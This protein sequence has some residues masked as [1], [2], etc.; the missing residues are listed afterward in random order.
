[1]L[2][3]TALPEARHSHQTA[4]AQ[5]ATEHLTPT[6][7]RFAAGPHAAD[8]ATAG[9][10]GGQSTGEAADRGLRDGSHSGQGTELSRSA[11]THATHW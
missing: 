7:S 2:P 11:A 3:A 8:Y 5:Q 6:N 9:V 4:A 1:M 10:D